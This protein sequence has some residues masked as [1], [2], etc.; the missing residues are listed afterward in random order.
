M[1]STDRES[2]GRAFDAF[3]EQAWNEHGDRP[4]EVADRLGMSLHLIDSPDHIAQ[5]A[6]LVAHVCGE[7]LGHWQRGIDLLNALRGLRGF[8]GGGTCA[9]AVTRGI[10]TLRYAGGDAGAVEQLSFDDRISVLAAVAA[11]CA[12]RR[13]FARAIAAYREALRLAGNDLPMQSAACRALAVGGNNL[14]AALE[15]KS[16]RTSDEVEG[17]IAAAEGGLKYWKLAGTWLEEERAEYRLARCLLQAGRSDA[18]I[19]SARRCVDVCERNDA[20]PFEQFFGQAVL[21]LAQRA[22][23][24]LDA[25]EPGRKLALQFYEQI[26]AQE[27][28]WCATEL[29]E[30]GH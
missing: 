26:P 1:N 28:Q 15:E 9:G 14:A 6:R 4:A 22:A 19:Q 5:Y 30:L 29:A 20:P 8:D 7:H 17:M 25:F 23:G 13:D 12:G 24:N 18:A 2:A 21:A 27:R 3:I 10:A 16:D 11:A